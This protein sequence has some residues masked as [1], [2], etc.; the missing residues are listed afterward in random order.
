[1][2]DLLDTKTV[3][4]AARS[5][6]RRVG[7][8]CV[9]DRQMERAADALA[10]VLEAVGELVERHIR[11]EEHIC[12]LASP[13]LL[14]LPLH[15]ATL[16]DGSPVLS[17]HCVSYAPNISVLARALADEAGLDLLRARTGVAVVGKQGDT[18]ALVAHAASTA[19]RVIERIGGATLAQGA[20][21]DKKRLLELAG[22]VEQLLFLGHGVQ[23][24]PANGRALC[25]AAD[26]SLP[27]APLPVELEPEL[28]RFLVDA[29]DIRKLSSAPRLLVSAACSSGRSLA[30][31]GG[32][33][34]GLEQALFIR[35][36]RTLLAPLWDVDGPAA[37]AF[38][39]TF[40]E[41]WASAPGAGVGEAYRQACLAT[42]ATHEKLFLW[43]PF[44]LSGN[45]T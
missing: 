45:W 10:P 2:V 3:S 41:L 17:R 34:R 31:P 27:G 35:G 4:D 21:V 15:A 16:G 39:E 38:L 25:V 32:I 30:G 1:L 9:T 28:R 19:A 24:I 26:G 22:E 13:A 36:T 6:W 5:F 44:A 14:G 33:R 29:E 8:G 23:S 7:P 43:G 12:I 18:Q 37:F 42:M 11:A 20:E 40:Y